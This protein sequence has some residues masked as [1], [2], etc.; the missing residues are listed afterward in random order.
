MH[1][2]TYRPFHVIIVMVTL[3]L[4]ACSSN[5]V[6]TW[7]PSNESELTAFRHYSAGPDVFCRHYAETNRKQCIDGQFESVGKVLEWA[8]ENKVANCMPW[9]GSA[10]TPSC[11]Q[12]PLGQHLILCHNAN[13]LS[14]I[15]T[16]NFKTLHAC[17]VG[18]G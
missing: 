6:D 15:E 14:E 16:Y 1:I 11:A 5:T 13:Y 17:I 8:R 7:K 4:S 10:A 12:E 18:D 2:K 3:L 9:R